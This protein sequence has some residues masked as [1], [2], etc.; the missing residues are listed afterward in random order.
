MK[1]K[2]LCLEDGITACGF[3][4]L[5]ASVRRLEPDTRVGFVSTRHYR[6][7]GALLRG[8]YGGRGDVDPAHVDE[9]ARGLVDADLVGFSSMTGYA[10]LTRAVI[11]RVRELSRRPYLVWGGIHP[12]MHPEDA[13]TSGVDAICTGEGEAAVEQLLD[14]LERGR[15]PGDLRNFW[16]ARDGGV[17]R[18]GFLPLMSGEELESLPFPLYGED[19]WI[20]EPGRGFVP[21]GLRHYLRFTSCSYVAI[22]TIGCP[23]HCTFCGNTRFIE[24]DR[25]YRRLRHPSA[26]Y[27][28]DEVKQVVR[29]MPHVSQVSFM[30][31][32]FLAVPLR[33][34]RELASLWREEIGL[35]FGVY[36]VIPNYVRRDKLDV[37]TAAGMTR[38]RMGI[39]SGSR[40][41]LDFYRR[42]S[43]PERV[44]RAAEVLASYAPER[45]MPPIYDVIVDNPIETRQDVVDTLELMYR[46]AR[47]F[48]LF[49]YSLKV[50]PNTRLERQLR[51]QGVDLEEISESYANVP[52]RLANVLL[53]L[54][55]LWRPPRWLFERLLAGVRASGEAPLHPVLGVVLRAAFL[56][57]W[58]FIH[59][60]FLEFTS[61][62]GGLGWLCWRVGLVDWRR[63][64]QRAARAR[65]AAPPERAGVGVPT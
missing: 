22:W 41:I 27:V 65:D 2:L 61:L 20:H 52:P 54:L 53:Y 63:R 31:D 25:N 24:N 6:S 50:I 60:R 29:R 19:E 23:L 46:L 36:G 35:P 28:V 59:L 1:I 8:S 42:P 21:M 9:I 16:F 44:E 43:P 62:P 33:Q 55:A 64:R 37:L 15:D 12:I 40:R 45:T 7:A 34:I 39:Q 18:N 56:G 10:G 47:P 48:T 3:R 5:A 11:A 26:R 49:V 17:V 30:D 13:I 32:S 4:K 14:R 57:R 51:Q 38:V 58:A